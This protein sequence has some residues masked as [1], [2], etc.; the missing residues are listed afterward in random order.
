MQLWKSKCGPIWKKGPFPSSPDD[1][2]ATVT[3]HFTTAGSGRLGADSP[4][5]ANTDTTVAT[6]LNHQ[7]D[8]ASSVPTANIGSGPLGRI[9]VK[10]EF[11]NGDSG[12]S[13]LFGVLIHA[14]AI[15]SELCRFLPSSDADANLTAALMLDDARSKNHIQIQPVLRGWRCRPGGCGGVRPR[16]RIPDP[17]FCG[18]FS[19][20]STWK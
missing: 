11:T 16:S 1:K 12:R 9:L 8:A 4:D 10:A 20:P 2:L 3:G 14:H 17:G 7:T 18:L 5:R 15:S 13:R 6:R 19:T